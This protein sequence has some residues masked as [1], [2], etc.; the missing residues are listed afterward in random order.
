MHLWEKEEIRQS[1][2]H[3]ELKRREKREREREEKQWIEWTCTWRV[4]CDENGGYDEEMER[5]GKQDIDAAQSNYM[6][7]FSW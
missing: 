7:G 5:S 4:A 6:A 1:R 2:E 3:K